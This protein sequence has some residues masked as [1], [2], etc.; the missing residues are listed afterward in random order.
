ML[1]SFT[2]NL[3]S[4]TQDVTAVSGDSGECGPATEFFLQMEAIQNPPTGSESDQPSRSDEPLPAAAFS[5]VPAAVSQNDGEEEVLS[6][7]ELTEECAEWISEDQSDKMALPAPPAALVMEETP[8]VRCAVCAADAPTAAAPSHD[9]EAEV[10]VSEDREYSVTAPRRVN[11]LFSEPVEAG[12]IESA[13]A[14]VSP[15]RP[16]GRKEQNAPSALENEVPVKNTTRSGQKGAVHVER[17]PVPPGAGVRHGSEELTAPKVAPVVTEKGENAPIPKAAPVMVEKGETASAPQVVRTAVE[18]TENSFV[19][20][21]APIVTENGEKAPILKAAPIVAESGEKAPVAK[22]APIV[23]ESGE[24]APVPKVVPTIAENG[25]SAPILKTVQIVAENG[26]NAPVPKAALI[27]AEDGENLPASAALDGGTNG[28][29]TAAQSRGPVEDDDVPPFDYAS[30]SSKAKAVLSHGGKGDVIA[31][32]A[33]QPVGSLPRTQERNPSGEQLRSP[34]ASPV[35]A[36]FE[37]VRIH[38]QQQAAPT[39][40]AAAA[41]NETLVHEISQRIRAQVLEGGGAIRIRLQP[42]R[43]GHIEIRAEL[44]GSGVVARVVADSESVKQYLEN[45]LPL[46]QH[47]LQEQGVRVDRIQ[48]ALHSESQ[49]LSE[50]AGRSAHEGSGQSESRPAMS[51][52]VART[53]SDEPVGDSSQWIALNPNVRF[54]TIA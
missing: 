27:V 39:I 10:S 26:E 32:A 37:P 9:A 29:K 42:D 17:I 6:G 3:P 20:K 4:V 22:A 46:L 41:E 25:E 19:S 33:P 53:L 5:I 52:K 48:F 12:P 38:V 8:A 24:N 13:P 1:V 7:N 43:F 34:K 15:P 11:N 45:N 21:V 54:H 47:H 14:A 30:G 44:T 49:S 36:T 18:N 23:S 16:E 51:A 40:V 2:T 50:H 28:E 35:M 31:V